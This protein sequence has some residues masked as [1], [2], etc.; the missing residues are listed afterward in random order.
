VTDNRLIT[1]HVT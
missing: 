1:K